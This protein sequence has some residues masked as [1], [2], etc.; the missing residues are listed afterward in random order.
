MK[1]FGTVT[2]TEGD[3]AVVTIIRDS[4]CGENCAACGICKNS[5]EMTIIIPN[6]GFNVGDK[7]CLTTDDKTF[8]KSSALGYLSLT[9]LLIAGGAIGGKLGGDWTAF[10]GALIGVLLGVVLIRCFFA[11]KIE[12]KTEKVER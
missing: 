5:K 9:A 6:E 4:A 3:K 7:V 1:K 8:L 11:E 12:I 10:L 2:K